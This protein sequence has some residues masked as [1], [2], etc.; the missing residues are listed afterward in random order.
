MELLT[1]TLNKSNGCQYLLDTL[2]KGQIMNNHP[3]IISIAT[4]ITYLSLSFIY[5]YSR[6]TLCYL[7]WCKNG[8]IIW[9]TFFLLLRTSCALGSLKKIKV[10]I[11]F[12]PWSSFTLLIFRQSANVSRIRLCFS[13]LYHNNIL[14]HVL[15]RY[16]S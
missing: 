11:N 6:A 8:S 14:L 9:T 13:Q 12:F 7:I 15:V 16:S 10:W 2:E 5:N 3:K 4:W 1:S